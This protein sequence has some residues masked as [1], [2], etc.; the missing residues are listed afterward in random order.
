VNRTAADGTPRLLSRIASAR[1]T[2]EPRRRTASAQDG[3]E[4]RR[5]TASAQDA[6]D[7]GTRGAPVTAEPRT[8]RHWHPAVPGVRA[9]APA[10]RCLAGGGSC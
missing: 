9:A 4:P 1:D 8:D 7:A 3:A 5:R 6:A 10:A 2:A